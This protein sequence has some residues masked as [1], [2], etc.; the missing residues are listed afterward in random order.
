MKIKILDEITKAILSKKR[1]EDIRKDVN[2]WRHMFSKSKINQIRKSFYDIKNSKNISKSKIKKIEKDLLDFEKD[3]SK[4]K[5]YHNY[6]E[7]LEVY[8]ISHSIKIITK[9]Q[10]KPSVVLI[11]RIII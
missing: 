5:K 4:P 7:M 3:L 9:N 10:Q 1:I 6:D 11:I 2:K 8:L